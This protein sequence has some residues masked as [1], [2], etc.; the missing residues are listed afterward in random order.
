M[1]NDKGITLISLIIYVIGM[2]IVVAI[3]SVVT[4]FFY[5]NINVKEIN[6]STILQYSKFSSIF[7]DEI[8]KEN[9]RIIDCKTYQENDNKISYIIFSS[10]NQYTYKG[11][12]KSIYKNKIRICT[13]I[14][15]CYFEY[16][17]ADSKYSIKV[18]FKTSETDMTGENA[19]IYTLK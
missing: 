1:M 13:E 9:N 15:D 3:I 4:A 14:E 2:T 10:G 12:N 8:N 7:L 11:E 19:M 6:D 5:K 18:N 16:T 17:F